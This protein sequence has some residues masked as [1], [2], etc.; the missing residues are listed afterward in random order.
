MKNKKIIKGDLTWTTGGK[1]KFIETGR[2]R[3]YLLSHNH[4][5]KKDGSSK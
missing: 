5:N 1:V 3:L 4:K 2:G